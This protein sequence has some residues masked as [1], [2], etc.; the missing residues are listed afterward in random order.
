MTFLSN[1]VTTPFI[2]YL[3]I[4]VGNRF[5]GAADVATMG[6]MIDRGAALS[7]WG[8]WIAS[9]AAPSL[10]LGLFVITAISAAIGY[11]LASF[12]WRIWIGR[13]WSQRARDRVAIPGA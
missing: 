2:L 1:P 12:G 3:S 13:K 10:I 7:E 11:L 4:V 8:N 9:A 5:M 6:R